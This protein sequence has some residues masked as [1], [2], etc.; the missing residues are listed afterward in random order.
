M[1]KQPLTKY[2][3]FLKP[4]QVNKKLELFVK[5]CIRGILILLLAT[6][7]A[8]TYAQDRIKNLETRLSSLVVDV[9]ALDNKIDISVSEVPI[10]EFVRGIATNTNL[11]ITIDVGLKIRISSNYSQVRVIDLLLFLCK[12]YKLDITVTGSILS[13]IPYT[14]PVVEAP[15][16]QKHDP[17]IEYTK[18]NDLVTLDLIN[19]S[20]NLVVRRLVDLTQK[21]IIIS[22]EVGNQLVTGYIKNTPFEAGLEKLLYTN[23]I[24]VFK[25]KD[26]FYIKRSGGTLVHNYHSGDIIEPLMVSAVKRIKSYAAKLD[27]DKF[28]DI[29]YVKGLKIIKRENNNFSYIISNDIYLLKQTIVIK[30]F[31]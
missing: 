12:E 27:E 14:E 26:D 15:K 29:A 23:K 2:T 3:P 22:P 18:E 4:E 25:T 31:N 17:K 10:Q 19:D 28:Q 1:G 7:T 9:P 24:S 11:N 8:N 6:V 13:I 16:P 5:A 20:L 30:I 21:N